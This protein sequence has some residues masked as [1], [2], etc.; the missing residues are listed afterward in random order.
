MYLPRELWRR[1]RA[2]PGTTAAIELPGQLLRCGVHA[3]VI[4]ALIVAAG[5]HSGSRAMPPP[6]T[7]DQ[8]VHDAVVL[9]CDTPARAE[10]DANR[11]VSRS[12]A[13]AGH[14]TDG[15]GNDRVLTI[16][17]YWKTN[18]IDAKELAAL[19][20]EATVTRCPLSDTVAR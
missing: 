19:T 5:C 1:Y 7:V 16:V 8:T 4:L 14:L 13:I 12:D 6:A 17:E 11:G 20:K 3:P 10:P 2:S 9:V 15:I 18:G